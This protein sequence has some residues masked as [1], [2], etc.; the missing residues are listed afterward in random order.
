MENYG[1]YRPCYWRIKVFQVDIMPS[2]ATR[3]LIL[4]EFGGFK[5]K[6]MRILAISGTKRLKLCQN[7]L[8]ISLKPPNS[9]ELGIISA[10]NPKLGNKMPC[11]LQYLMLI[12]KLI[13]VVVPYIRYV[14]ENFQG[15]KLTC[16]YIKYRI[17]KKKIHQKRTQNFII[18]YFFFVFLRKLIIKKYTFFWFY[19][20]F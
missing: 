12:L 7:S 16:I 10:L 13:D 20:Y 19:F 15:L 2:I 14:S 9:L 3:G 1:D 8:A 17:I 18:F 6:T 5:L 4:D 11:T